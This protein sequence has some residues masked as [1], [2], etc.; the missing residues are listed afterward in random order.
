MEK[1]SGDVC[2][3]IWRSSKCYQLQRSLSAET[4]RE[5]CQKEEKKAPFGRALL[6]PEAAHTVHRSRAFRREC[7]TRD[8]PIQQSCQNNCKIC[9]FV[10]VFQWD[11]S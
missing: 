6:C 9:F 7:F 8:S 5:A 10:S 11:P 2:E 1:V 4:V 3:E